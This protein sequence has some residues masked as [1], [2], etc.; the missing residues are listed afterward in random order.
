[1]KQHPDVQPVLV[2]V[3]TASRA[4]GISRAQLYKMFDDGTIPRKK[5]GARTLVSYAALQRF[6]DEQCAD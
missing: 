2:D 4:L 6:A 1:M 3:V 5:I